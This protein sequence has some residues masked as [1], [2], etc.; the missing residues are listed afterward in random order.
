[1]TRTISFSFATIA[2]LALGATFLSTA[3]AA[4]AAGG[5]YCISSNET[6]VDCSFRSLAQCEATASGGLGECS[7]TAP[8]ARG[9]F[10]FGR[11]E[12]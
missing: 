3:P 11:G 5:S 6:G 10:A 7:M 8:F 1:M 9:R 2:A 4:A 12:R